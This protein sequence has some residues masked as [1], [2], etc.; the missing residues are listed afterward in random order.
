MLSLYFVGWYVP[1][2]GL[3]LFNKWFFKHWHGG[4]EFPIFVTMMHFISNTLLSRLLL[5]VCKIDYDR[6]MSW[7]TWWM[8]VVPIGVGTAVDIVLSNIGYLYLSVSFI[9]IIKSAGPV[10]LLIWSFVLKLEQPNVPLVV[11]IVLICAGAWLAVADFSGEDAE[12]QDEKEASDTALGIFLVGLATAASGMRWA[13]AQLLIQAG[14]TKMHPVAALRFT[15]PVCA[16][17]ILPGFL[18]I[19][20]STLSQSEFLEDSTLIATGAGLMAL[21]AL[22]ALALI[23]AEFQ[24]INVYSAVTMT[25]GGVVKEL[26]TIS[27]AV[28]FFAEDLTWNNLVGAGL[29]IV[30]VLY[31]SYHKSAVAS[32]TPADQDLFGQ[33]RYEST[34]SAPH[35]VMPIPKLELTIPEEAIEL[36]TPTTQRQKVPYRIEIE[37]AE[38]LELL[39]QMTM[40][41]DPM[42]QGDDHASLLC[43]NHSQSQNAPN[44]SPG[45]TDKEGKKRH[46][47]WTRE[48]E[49]KEKRLAS[50]KE[51]YNDLNAL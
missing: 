24:I 47:E 42:M 17:T 51:R 11:V 30:A 14:F 43:S 6:N 46:K 45:S 41:Q 28:A 35:Q 13:M 25:I 40:A 50:E 16:L 36:S 27:M 1:S 7:R 48:L 4:F 37:E 8:Q 33:V 49:K 3:T 12:V 32:R 19:E 26:L 23:L 39:N 20:A 44:S 34:P 31:Y 9:T 2:I 29:V 15:A 5:Y 10:W 22:M 18:F 21:A 38:A